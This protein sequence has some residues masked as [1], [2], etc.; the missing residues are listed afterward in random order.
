MERKA[1]ARFAAVAVAIAVAA[2]S[3]RSAPNAVPPTSET[4]N[5]TPPGNRSAHSWRGLRV[6]GV[7]IVDA[8]GSDVILKGF[9]PGEWTNT[10]AYMI[11]W[12]D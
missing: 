9:G 5:Q 7:H 1:I 6:D 3:G 10:E 4:S 12:P 11:L 8:N 2:C